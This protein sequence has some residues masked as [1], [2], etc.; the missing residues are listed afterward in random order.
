MAI[1]VESYRLWLQVG[2]G[3]MW[4]WAMSFVHGRL[5]HSM[6]C[7]VSLL[8]G[9]L[10]LLQANTSETDS[11]KGARPLLQAFCILSDRA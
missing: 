6:G 1:T 4:G 8:V 10:Q 3:H 9:S 5:E 2:W 11:L 7:A